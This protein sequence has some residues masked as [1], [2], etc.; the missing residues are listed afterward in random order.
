ME[1][2]TSIYSCEKTFKCGTF[3]YDSA[4]ENDFNFHMKSNH[5]I[6]CDLCSFEGDLFEHNFPCPN[7][8]NIFR[9]TDKHDTNICKLEIINPTFEP[10][11]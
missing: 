7:C 1:E 5:V 6:K 3:D 4:D 8:L 11:I 10:S 9:T 2:A